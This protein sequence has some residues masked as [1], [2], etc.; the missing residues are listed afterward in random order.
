MSTPTIW[1]YGDQNITGNYTQNRNF[2]VGGQGISVNPVFLT[3]NVLT[4]SVSSNIGYLA[5]PWYNLYATGANVTVLNVT[6]VA[7]LNVNTPSS[8]G[9]PYISNILGNVFTSNSVTAQS[10]NATTMNTGTL[11]LVSI[12]QNLVIGTTT[13]PGSTLYI[14]GNIFVSDSI[15]TQNAFA[16]IMNSASLNASTIVV[17]TALGGTGAS[18]YTLGNAIF[19]NA[20]T[21]GDIFATSLNINSNVTT[22]N[23]T[24]VGLFSNINTSTVNTSSLFA[25]TLSIGTYDPSTTLNVLGNA[26]VS[27]TV[28]ANIF[29]AQM[30]VSG[31]S[32]I[33]AISGPVGLGGAGNMQTGLLVSGNI[34][35]S[36]ALTTNNVFTGNFN[37]PIMYT[38][39]LISPLFQVYYYFQFTTMGATGPYGPSSINYPVLPLGGITLSGGIQYWTVPLTASYSFTVAGAGS[40]APSIQNTV[41]VGYGIVLSGTYTLNAGDILAIL[42]GQT[43]I[44][45]NQNGIDY[46]LSGSGGSGGTFIVKVA[47]VGNFTGA[48]PLFIAGGAAGLGYEAGNGNDNINGTIS[49]T[50]RSGSIGGAGAGSAG[51]SGGGASD[52]GGGGAGYNGDGQLISGVGAQTAALSLTHLGTGGKASGYT[53]SGGF[54][55]GGLGWGSAGGGGGGYGGGGGGNRDGTGAGG[56]GGGSYD[57][58]SVYSGAATNSGPGYVTI[59]TGYVTISTGFVNNAYV[60][61]ALTAQ[62]VLAIKAVTTTINVSSISGTTL[63]LGASTGGASL[64]VLGNIFSGNVS[65]TNVYSTLAN[66]TNSITVGI[67]SISSLALG[68]QG[69]NLTTQGNIFASNSLTTTNIYGTTMNISS[70]V[71]SSLFISS[72]WGGTGAKLYM[73]GNAFVSNSLTAT[74][75]FSTNANLGT[76]N[77]TSIYGPSGLVGVGTAPSASLHILGNIFVSNS[78]ISQNLTATGTFNVTY[79]N[80]AQTLV[81]S[82]GISGATLLVQ[83]NAYVSNALITQNIF[84]SVSNTSII[85][86][87]SLLITGTIGQPGPNLYISGNTF[88]SNSLTTTNIFS[89]TVYS[90]NINIVSGVTMIA[91]VS[92]PNAGG[93]NLYVQGNVFASNALSATNV[94]VTGVLNTPTINLIGSIFSSNVGIGT[95]TPQGASIYVQG[96]SFVSNSVSTTNFFITNSL[97]FGTINTASFS[98]SSLTIG[99]GVPQ[100]STTFVQGN[101]FVS[102][103]LTATNVYISGSLNAATINTTT[104]TVTSN[105][106]IGTATPQGASIYVQGNSYVSNSLT[107]TNVYVSGSLNVATINSV[108]I[109]FTS[110]VGIGNTPGSTNLYVQGNVYISGTLAASNIISSNLI[111]TVEDLTLRSPHLVPNAT[112]GP[113]IQAWISATCNASSQPQKSWWGTSLN[114]DFS[115]RIQIQNGYKGGLLL[116]D[117]RVLFVPAYAT[118]PAFYQSKTRTLSTVTINGLTSGT[119]AN[120]VLLPSGNVIFCPQTSNVGLFNPLSSQFSNSVSLPGGSYCGVLSPT[121]NVIFT[122]TGVPSN[123]IHYNHT[124]GLQANCYALSPFS[125]FPTNPWSGLSAGLPSA[126][127]WTAASWSDQLG[128]FCAVSATGPTAISPD[129]LNWKIGSQTVGSYSRPSWSPE[130][131]LFCIKPDGTTSSAVSIDGLTWTIGAAAGLS[132]T[133]TKAIAWSSQLGIF[134]L[135]CQVTSTAAMAIS[136][137]GLTWTTASVNG[138]Y[139]AKMVWAPQLGIFC[140]IG[141]S[142]SSYTSSTSPDGLTWSS[143]VNPPNIGSWTSLDWSPQLGIFCAVNYSNPSSVTGYTSATS[144]TGLSW[145]T[146]TNLPF[147]QWSDVTWSPQL[148]LF[149]AV[150][151]GSAPGYK[152]SAMSPDGVNWTGFTNLPVNGSINSITWSPPLGVFCTVITGGSPSSAITSN[153]YSA[154]KTG[155]ILLPNGNVI[156]SSPGSSNVIQYNPANLTGSNLAVGTA[157]FNGLVLSPNGNVIGVP[158]NSNILVINPSSFTC[159]N[160]IVPRSN[161]NCTVFFGGGCLVPSGNIIFAPSLTLTANVGSSNVGMFDPIALTFSNSS[162]AGAGFTGATLIPNGQVVFCPSGVFDTM[163]PVSREFCM[164]PYLNKF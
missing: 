117:G 74:N 49:T 39:S 46:A 152:Y 42:V 96:N 92:L 130:L 157:G 140:L 160:I 19:T 88:V 104:L 94:F 50:G 105:M 21:V 106:R 137:D 25:G 129:G 76:A 23:L 47:S 3:T 59:S 18:L 63:A 110:N 122:P 126:Y 38:Y 29:A 34:F 77:V 12:S 123:I 33:G 151:Y 9:T 109:I 98:P 162:T 7:T 148:G 85:N 158:Q 153:M 131:G 142:G 83:G 45:N 121:G 26:Y 145:S 133:K 103:S 28:T 22:G 111:Y 81:P 75:V 136:R 95:A 147:Q 155:S 82:I 40:S 141:E 113:I 90:P 55:G 107:S 144:R 149:C 135:A 10:I 119:F 101:V 60:S 30:N 58:N 99:V 69:A 8:T 2:T 86:T 36:N 35:V 32:N 118:S 56:G 20:L 44:V 84:A 108:T 48:T 139:W 80:M 14:G 128:V 161:A 61:N 41:K 64:S 24:S 89:N 87:P 132:T 78:L 116:P 51:P 43:G 127:N 138:G 4:A 134:C 67:P 102:N 164:S 97:T 57:I 62:S 13:P 54:G 91:G 11:S 146:N 159:S 143:A 79:L 93:A 150:A 70:L 1:Y 68:G 6:S 65:T 72:N 125:A 114:P 53:A 16:T 124:T 37:T 71:T 31:I 66:I 163:T 5:A 17:S 73:Y 15:T 156:A 100:G 112:N 154:I 115:N 27:G 120:G 52:R